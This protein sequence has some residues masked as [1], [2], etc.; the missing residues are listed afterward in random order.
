MLLTSGSH[1]SLRHRLHQEP[2]LGHRVEKGDVEKRRGKQ[3]RRWGPA[4]QHGAG[5][6]A[7]ATRCRGQR[8]S[9]SSSSPSPSCTWAPLILLL[10]TNTFAASSRGL[11]RQKCSTWHMLPS[12][13]TMLWVS[14]KAQTQEEHKHKW[15]PLRST[16]KEHVQSLTVGV[17]EDGPRTI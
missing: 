7:A 11:P 2:P 10:P 17:S 9:P 13:D 1:R 15:D 8:P 14:S 12:S 5:G 3:P 16:G 4:S 6:L